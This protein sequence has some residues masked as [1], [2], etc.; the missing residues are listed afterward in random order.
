MAERKKAKEESLNLVPIMNLV[1]ILI[2]VLLVAI[3]SVEI[4]MIETKLPAI[5]APSDQTQEVPD[6]PPLSL[7][8]G[9]MGNGLRI[10]GADEYLYPGG[11]PTAA[12]GEGGRPPT[13]PCK[14]G[15]LCR[16]INDYNWADLN[17]KLV[18]IKKQAIDDG[19]DSPSVILVPQSTTRYEI[20]V[21]TMDT[22]RESD[23]MKLFDQVVIA[24]GAK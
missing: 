1:T 19:R 9:I 17:K 10:I 21:K 12:A 13:V 2:P 7:S 16:D 18:D 20:I 5:G 6:K 22:A 8:I 3:K 11:A 23:D 14:S 24:G 15:A 4:A